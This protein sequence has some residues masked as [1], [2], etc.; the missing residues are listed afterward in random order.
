MKDCLSASFTK[1]LSNNFVF[2]EC[3]DIIIY[4]NALKGFYN[5]KYSA[6]GPNA[7]AGKKDKAATIT[8]TANTI[9]PKVAVS[10]FNVPA[11]SG[12][13]FLFANM[14]AIAT[15]PIIGR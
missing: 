9:K 3:F 1:L 8:I 10:V 11:L 14:P 2:L 4:L 7:S 15:G 5:E 13:Y 12:I 6:I